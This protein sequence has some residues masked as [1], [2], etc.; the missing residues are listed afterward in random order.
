MSKHYL[1]K[2]L[3]ARVYDVASESPLEVATRLSDRLKNHV[4]LKREDVQEIFSFK[5]RGAYNKIF[6]LSDDEK[7]RGVI[8]ASA[9][10]HA[11]GVALAGKK[12][13]IPTT[14]IMPTTTPAIKVDMVR[15]LGG[16]AL[17]KGDS[18]DEAKDYALK[19]SEK[20]NLCFIHP[21]DDPQVI[22]VTS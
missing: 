12:L 6:H 17:L 22:A 8:A 15:R 18:Y 19:L 21:F 11:Q 20:N 9:G 3:R 14:I 7:K 4:L 1:E 13:N 5:L 10:N 2:I 16:K